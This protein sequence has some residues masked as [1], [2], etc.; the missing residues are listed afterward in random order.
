[1]DLLNIVTEPFHRWDTFNII[2]LFLP[3]VS[4]VPE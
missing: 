1:M 4:N 3:Q 2:N